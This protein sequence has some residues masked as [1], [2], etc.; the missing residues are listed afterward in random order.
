MF[1]RYCILFANI[2]KNPSSPKFYSIPFF[3]R[4]KKC[5][6]Y[7]KLCDYM[8]FLACKAIILSNIFII[9]AIISAIM[10]LCIGNNFT[11]Y[12]YGE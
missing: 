4:N 1:Y 3:A 12:N 6:I 5:S 10:W 9:F 11:R 2:V 7:N 8:A